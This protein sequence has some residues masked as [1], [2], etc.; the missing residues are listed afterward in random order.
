MS[1]RAAI[2][3]LSLPIAFLPLV[4]HSQWQ[5]DGVLVCGASHNQ[6]NVVAISGGAGGAI[7]AW[8]DARNGS[9]G[10]IYA[11]R[12]DA[13]GHALW[14]PDGVAVCT[15]PADQSY[16][17]LLSDGAGGAI[18]AWTD[19]RNGATS[20]FDIYAQRVDGSGAPQWTPNGVAVC[21]ATGG[22][23][24]PKMT[25]NG[26]GGAIVV[27]DDYRNG[28]LNS[29]VYAARLTFAGVVPDGPGG[30]A[31]S[32]GPTNESVPSLT[33]YGS[34]GAIIAWI[35]S[36]NG[37]LDI[38]A[39]RFSASG[40]VLDPRGLAVCQY[41]S[42]QYYPACVG[43]GAGGA[44]IAWSDARIE[45]IYAQRINSAGAVQWTPN[46]VAVGSPSGS[47]VFDMPR[48]L[49]DGAGGA[50]IAWSRFDGP[51]D[52]NLY[53]QRISAS[54]AR[55]WLPDEV[56]V[57]TD[58]NDQRLSTMTSDNAGGVLV[59]WEDNRSGVGYD[60]YAQRVEASGT[61]PWT[62]N[63]V[64]VCQADF[65]QHGPAA[66]S[67]GTG[68]AIVAWQDF[69]GY[70]ESDIYAQRV[71]SDGQTPTGVG[72]APSAP[73]TFLPARPNPFAQTTDLNVRLNEPSDV[74]FDVFDVAGRRVRGVALT[75][76]EAGWRR[77]AFDGRDDSGHPL[78]SG[79]YF[80]RIEASGA[81]VMQKIELLK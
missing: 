1:S 15:A 37:S 12:M 40:V 56:P 64:V 51:S 27:W 28:S 53:A 43:D 33:P 74:S 24:Y 80:C 41:A 14:A 11:Q 78:P 18:I 81:K 35:D 3:F 36:R 77:I 39:T 67:D 75:N 52:L 55:Q 4:G 38:F 68:G 57:C 60:V 45:A 46:G 22:Q 47:S 71:G 16:A 69:R 26:S 21:T 50:L 63:G 6:S 73:F 34:G 30:I 58:P 32:S 5:P 70:F 10:D 13:G 19:Y 72:D 62:S 29:D 31:I 20:S 23:Y 66:V 54:G 9:G 76:V 7:I 61:V 2:A 49:P 8:T 65:D 48:T 25:S 17:T 79:V 44:I 42:D 59:V